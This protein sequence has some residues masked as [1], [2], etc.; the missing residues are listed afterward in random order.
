MK[1]TPTKKFTAIKKIF[2][3]SIFTTLGLCLSSFLFI[4]FEGDIY[5]WW[6][7]LSIPK[8]DIF[9]VDISRR[10][11][12]QIY[13]DQEEIHWAGTKWTDDG[14]NIIIY[15]S[16]FQ[17]YANKLII[18]D[19]ENPS[20]NT[21]NIQSVEES[22]IFGLVNELPFNLE[23]R[24]TLWAGCSN[25]NLFFTGKYTE[26][27]LWETRLWKG[28]QLIKIFPPV[29]INFHIYDSGFN[30]DPVA[31]TIE[32]SN[33]S[34]DCRYFTMHSYKETWILDTVNQ[35][36]KPLMIGGVQFIS[37]RIDSITGFTCYQCVAPIWSPNS[38]EFV[39][40]SNVGIE[41]YDIL[42]NQR[43]LLVAPNID[44]GVRNIE[45][46]HWSNTGN[47]ILGYFKSN[48]S[49]ISQDGKKIG[50][51]EDCESIQQPLWSTEDIETYYSSDVS[52]SPIE[53]KL[54]FI[55]N[56][57]DKSTCMDGKCEK[58]AEYLIIWDLSNLE[59]N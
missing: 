50:V 58:E 19:S 37:E 56:Q 30:D 28:S 46:Q 34:P 10:I 12:L 3:I 13:S 51:L 1:K 55:C 9:Q 14:K 43:S 5:K 2:L 52:W 23:D 4:V 22:N 11:V 41:K 25:Q 57:Y 17:S 54:A 38:H 29:D 59:N 20:F 18:I 15:N 49:I 48:H 21:N 47:W 36:F 24:E 7:S 40:Q 31:R 45:S 44:I 16:S 53:D 42:L 6:V 39:F 27:N 32:G 26:N 33:F 35:S 8:P